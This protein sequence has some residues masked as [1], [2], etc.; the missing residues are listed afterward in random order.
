MRTVCG[1]QLL[2]PAQGEAGWGEVGWTGWGERRGGADWVGPGV[3][4]AS[5][6]VQV[7]A[8]VG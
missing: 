4:Q 6:A 3:A 1:P 7:R 8:G 2:A 5:A